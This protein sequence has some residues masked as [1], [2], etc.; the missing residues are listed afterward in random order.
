MNF[1]ELS[2]NLIIDLEKSNKPNEKISEYIKSLG[3]KILNDTMV[4]LDKFI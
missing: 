3:Q 1:D 4:L 2:N